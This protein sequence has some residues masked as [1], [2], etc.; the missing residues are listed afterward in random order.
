[1]F[2]I[3]K[4]LVI[5]LLVLTGIFLY[6]IEP[7]E[8]RSFN[9]KPYDLKTEIQY[10]IKNIGKWV[11]Q[12]EKQSQPITP[13]KVFDQEFKVEEFVTGLHSPTTM[14]F[15]GNDVLVLE[16]QSGKVRLIKN[17]KLEEDPVLDVEVNSFG[18]RGMLGIL[19]VKSEV[20]LYFTKSDIDEGESMGNY[21]YKYDWNGRFLENPVLLNI[22]P[23]Y[24]AQHNGGAM[25]SDLAGNVY[26]VIGD[27]TLLNSPINQYRVL[28]NYP[29]G[30]PDDTGVIIKVGLNKSEPRPSLS[31]NSL[32]HYYA[33]GIR[34]SFGLAIDH[35][36]GKM[37]DTENGP[38]DFDEIN[39][40]EP[41]FNS[42]WV[43][44]MGPATKEEL[45]KIPS[46]GDFVYSDP[47]FSWEKPVAPT[48]IVFPNTEHFEKYSNSLFVGDCNNGN[49]YKFTL[50]KERTS[51]VFEDEG[52]SDLVVNITSTDNKTIETD[53]MKEILFGKGF[54]C[55]TDLEF[56]PDGN[57]YVVSILG[58]IFRISP[59]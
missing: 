42:G 32:D 2:T 27:Q 46:F 44:S 29:M 39:L 45:S 36:T 13:T 52:L 17:G 14:A 59:V 58:E 51:F 10:E 35:Q 16:K 48:A 18:E 38:E 21:I 56:G 25:V 24:S 40:V 22:L 50:N 53:S 7:F 23:G 37:W 54:G 3:K 9:E 28:Q 1:M 26:A 4:L 55:I 8:I 20:Y 34:N 31:S 57:L 19:T 11:I 6:W 15:V 30:Q 33:M 49:I 43:I 12:L 47:E 41:K 5:S